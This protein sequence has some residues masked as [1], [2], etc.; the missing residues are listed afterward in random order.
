MQ[1]KS[2]S[3]LSVECFSVHNANENRRGKLLYFKKLFWLRKVSF[4]GGGHHGFVE[5]LM[6]LTVARKIVGEHFGVS[7]K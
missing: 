5:V 6:F 7:E 2:K 3:L 4:L 1:K